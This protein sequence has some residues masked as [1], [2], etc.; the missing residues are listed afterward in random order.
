MIQMLSMCNTTHIL[1]TGNTVI[2]LSTVQSS[3]V[4]EKVI[5]HLQII[6]EII[7]VTRALCKTCLDKVYNV[8]NT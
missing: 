5:V 7:H 4:P 2:D 6:C 8:V 3:T 1:R